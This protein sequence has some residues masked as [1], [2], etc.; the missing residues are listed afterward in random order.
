MERLSLGLSCNNVHRFLLEKQHS[1]LREEEAERRQQEQQPTVMNYHLVLSETF[2]ISGMTMVVL[3]HWQ[4]DTNMQA[5]SFTSPLLLQNRNEESAYYTVHNSFRRHLT[6]GVEVAR[7]QDNAE[8]RFIIFHS[9]LSEPL[10]EARMSTEA[11]ERIVNYGVSTRS[12]HTLAAFRHD[13]LVLGNICHSSNN[14]SED[15]VNNFGVRL[16]VDIIRQLVL[17]AFYTQLNNN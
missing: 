13:G 9:I 3:L 12:S 7:Q 8:I 15:W 2:W 14:N 17:S 1:V 10:A 6:N 16:Q 4:N 11:V 5:V